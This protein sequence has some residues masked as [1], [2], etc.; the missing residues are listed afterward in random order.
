MSEAGEF[1]TGAGPYV[2][3]AAAQPYMV[4]P[5]LFGADDLVRAFVQARIRE[6]REGGFG[7]STALGVVRDGKL[8]GGVVYNNF[9]GHDIHA[10]YAFDN[11]KWASR[12]VLRILFGYPFNQLGVVRMTA[13]IGRRNKHARKMVERLGFKQEGVHPKAVDGRQDA[14]SYGCLRAN[15]K[16]IEPRERVSKGEVDGQKEQLAAARA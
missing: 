3:T 9:N 14:I 12:A 10:S 4:G 16:W 2:R 6:S 8:L 15:C 5:V 7:P 13:V 11:P 1:Y